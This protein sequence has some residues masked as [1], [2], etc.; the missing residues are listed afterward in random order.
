MRHPAPRKQYPWGIADM[1]SPV[2][3]ARCRAATRTTATLAAIAT[4]LSLSTAAL[5][6][7][8]AGGLAEP[9]MEP[10]V[11]AAETVSS[12]HGV[13]VPLLALLFFGTAAA[14]AK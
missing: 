1:T 11:I 5:A 14:A 3:R 4:A 7:A 12:S 9:V 2:P 13:L 10:A 6:P 8:H